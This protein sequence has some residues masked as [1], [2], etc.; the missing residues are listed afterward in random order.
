MRDAENFSI[1]PRGDDI[2]E[3]FSE[4]EETQEE[5]SQ[6]NCILIRFYG[7]SILVGLFNDKIFFF[8]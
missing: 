3:L 4:V 2:F 5:M 7:M 1:S 8:K 6:V